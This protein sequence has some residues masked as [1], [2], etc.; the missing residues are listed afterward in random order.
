M[1][2]TGKLEWVR[3]VIVFHAAIAVKPKA[4]TLGES[5]TVFPQGACSRS[6][7][8]AGS[9]LSS[10]LHVAQIAHACVYYVEIYTTLLRLTARWV[11]QN[12]QEHPPTPRGM[13]QQ[14]ECRRSAVR[15]IAK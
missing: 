13:I 3:P 9:Q 10:L 1:S 6:V 7:L 12:L 5:Y 8:T 2:M 14:L 11:Q 15:A 4:C